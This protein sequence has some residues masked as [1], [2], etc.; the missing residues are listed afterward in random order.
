M[1]LQENGISRPY[2]CI[3]PEIIWSS[4]EQHTFTEGSVCFPG[5]EAKVTR[6]SS[7]KLRYLDYDGN[8]QELEASGFFASVIQHEVDYLNGKVYLDY[9]SKLKR[10]TLLKKM[11]KYM[12]SDH[13]HV[14]SVYCKH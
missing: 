9:L 10:D 12:A 6:P 5:I 14:H 1:D 13:H 3:N 4:K 2:K 8:E 7:V 11:Q